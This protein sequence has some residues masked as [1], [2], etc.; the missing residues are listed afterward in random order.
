MWGAMYACAATVCADHRITATTSLSLLLP[1]QPPARHSLLTQVRCARAA[2]VRHAVPGRQ[3]GTYLPA[4][5]HV[6]AVEGLR[7]LNH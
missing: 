2:G 6:G 7:A 1:P 5:G 3:P 4:G